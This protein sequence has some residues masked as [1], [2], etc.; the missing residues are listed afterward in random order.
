MGFQDIKSKLLIDQQRSYIGAALASSNLSGHRAAEERPEN[1][2][3]VAIDHGAESK[4]DFSLSDVIRRKT[5]TSTVLN[6]SDQRP[7]SS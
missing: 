4:L 3:A 5:V 7:G 2:E 6:K 1:K